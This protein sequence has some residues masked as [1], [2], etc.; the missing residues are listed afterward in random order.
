[1]DINGPELR[2]ANGR[3][4]ILPGVVQGV[5]L[6]RGVCPLHVKCRTAH[7]ARHYC[8]CRAVC[9]K[10]VTHLLLPLLFETSLIFG[11]CGLRQAHPVWPVV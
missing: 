6:V 11:W 4:C 3:S 10:R 8:F 5:L 7:K 2:E 1:M 9:P